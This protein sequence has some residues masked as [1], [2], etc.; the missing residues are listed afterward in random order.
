MVKLVVFDIGQTLVEYK[1]PLNW[2]LLSEPALSLVAQKC[3][4]TLSRQDIENA[5]AILK[6]YNTR[7]TPREYEVKSDYIFGEILTKWN[8]PIKDITKIKEIYYMYF[9]NDCHLYGD[10]RETLKEIK[11]RGIFTATLSDVAYG[12]DNKYALD[13]IAEVIRYIDIPFTSNDTGLRK[14]NPVGIRMLADRLKAETNEIIFVGDE[15]KDIA[16]ANNASV[17]SVLINRSGEERNYGQ[18]KTISSLN[19]LLSIID[20]L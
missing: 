7:I 8:K 18:C 17:Y 12:M 2:N 15:E 3:N 1:K 9:R 14:P 5:K 13:D 11:S 19:E 4:Y 16:C 20:I 6:K 10:V